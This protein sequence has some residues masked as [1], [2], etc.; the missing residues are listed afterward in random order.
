MTQQLIR[1]GDTLAL[2]LDR[3]LV[4][5]LG[6]DET[7]RVSVRVDGQSMIISTDPSRM[8]AFGEAMN[9]VNEEYREVFKRLAE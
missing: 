1:H 6:L 2:V 5:R 8:M 4:E 3:E 9:E 7:S